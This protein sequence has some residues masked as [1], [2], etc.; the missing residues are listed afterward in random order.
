MCTPRCAPYNITIACC[1]VISPINGST[2]RPRP[3]QAKA[4][5]T[6]GAEW[7]IH[8]RAGSGIC[9]FVGAQNE[10]HNNS[11]PLL[12]AAGSR[13]NCHDTR[14]PLPPSYYVGFS[15]SPFLLTVRFLLCAHSRSP[16]THRAICS[17]NHRHR[18]R[19]LDGP[20]G[21]DRSM[22]PACSMLGPSM[23]GWLA[24]P[25]WCFRKSAIPDHPQYVLRSRG[26]CLFLVHSLTHRL[27][28]TQTV[29]WE[30][31]VRT[32]E[33]F[34]GALSHTNCTGNCWLAGSMVA[35]IFYDCRA[36]Q[37]PGSK[38]VTTYIRTSH[39]T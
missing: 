30:F 18:N 35:F 8:S 27:S 24:I 29:N 19:Q 36:Q 33:G 1:Y 17:H 20:Q 10:N 25:W 31:V 7:Y 21:P 15:C 26:P 28:H 3:V 16:A 12:N 9:W 23:G 22:P 11:S 14:H 13:L 38:D 34:M 39:G 2:T 32:E 37:S 6:R 4:T 5:G